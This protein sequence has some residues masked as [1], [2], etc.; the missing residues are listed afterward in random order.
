[1]LKRPFSCLLGNVCLWIKKMAKVAVAFVLLS[2]LILTLFP[3]SSF[4]LFMPK[5]ED[6]SGTLVPLQVFGYCTSSSS[7]GTHRA[8]G[9][10]TTHSRTM[11]LSCALSSFPLPWP[12]SSLPLLGFMPRRAQTR[13]TL[14]ASLQPSGIPLSPWPHLSECRPCVGSWPVSQ[15]HSSF[16]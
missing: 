16:L 3:I 2:P 1:M 14:L 10:W 8:C 4:P 9:F 15:L 11:P 6:V 12:S 13:P 5:N 7:P